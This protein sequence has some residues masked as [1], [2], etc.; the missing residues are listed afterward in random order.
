LCACTDV[1]VCV[2]AIYIYRHVINQIKP[3]MK[4]ILRTL[5]ETMYISNNRKVERSS[6]NHSNMTLSKNDDSEPSLKQKDTD[7]RSKY[8]HLH[9]L[10]EQL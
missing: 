6:Q 2:R 7:S 4:W 1:C 3:V 8:I 9:L 10:F 5:I